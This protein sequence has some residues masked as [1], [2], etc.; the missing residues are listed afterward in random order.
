MN[1][2][3]NRPETHYATSGEGQLAYQQFGK[4]PTDLVYMTSTESHAEM[5]WDHPIP[6]HYYE[7]LASF[8]RVLFFDVRG[9]GA[10][11]PVPLGRP[12]TPESWTDDARVVMDAAGVERAAVVA[13]TEGGF[14]GL[15]FAAL[16]PERTTALVLIN[17]FAKLLR[18]EDYPIGIPERV[19]QRIIA[20]GR[21]NWGRPDYY[22]LMLPSRAD[23]RAFMEWL[24]KYQRVISTPNSQLTIYENFARMIDLRS[25]LDSIQA[26]T[27]IICRKDAAFHRADYSRYMAEHIPNAKLVELPGA[28]SHPVF[29]ADSEP[30]LDEIEEFVTGVRST[31]VPDRTLATVMFTDIVDSTGHAA[32][33]GDRG[34]LEALERQHQLT[35]NL[36]DRYRGREVKSTGDGVV[37]TFDG[38]TRAVTCAAQVRQGTQ[39][40]GFDLRV[41]LHTGE[42]ELVGDDISGMAVNIAARITDLQSGGGVTAS[43]TVRDL[44]VGSGIEFTS[45]G[46]YELKGVPNKWPIYEL[47]S[48][49][50]I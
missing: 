22:K 8:S 40:M 10:S 4:G 38:P 11:D 33:L 2:F 7:R 3:Y 21:Q 27:L 18:S 24:A 9:A 43:G 37:A 16:H 13:E 50:V 30:V 32:R 6:A 20:L 14:M 28:D 29:A 47:V 25:I 36:L 31:T 12:P 41:G 42:I 46:L 35:R 1:L 49:P 5:I 34:W 48:V 26:P 23:D 19:L 45:I 15:T 44:V 39:E 17:S